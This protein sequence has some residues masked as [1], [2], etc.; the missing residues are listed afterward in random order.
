MLR[1]STAAILWD[2]ARQP[3]FAGYFQ[4]I[5]DQQLTRLHG[6]LLA[7]LTEFDAICSRHGLR[8][9]VTAGTLIGAV[10]NDGFIPW[11]DDADLV[12]PREDYEQLL[13]L[14]R[15][16]D[17]ATRCIL[18]SPADIDYPLTHAAFYDPDETFETVLGDGFDLTEPISVDVLPVD[19]VPLRP[20]SRNLRAIVFSILSRSF[21]SLRV[22][23]RNDELLAE[24]ARQD[25]ELRW[26]VRMRRILAMPAVLLG[27]RRTFRLMERIAVCDVANPNQV[28]IPLGAMGY[29][30]EMVPAGTFFPAK[31]RLLS[32][33]DV[34]VPADADTYLSQRYGD[35][36][37]PPPANRRRTRLVRRRGRWSTRM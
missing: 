37:S 23:A 20:F 29:R 11:D 13:E 28:T 34:C 32:G 19:A 25:R 18:Q 1:T 22:L 16:S 2:L 15:S 8:Y 35:Y 7:L 12:M 26:N 30:G 10:R 5:T 31:R 36:L 6:Q 24:L 33:L 14:M 4:E 27:Q 9:C 17:I 21:S 3:R